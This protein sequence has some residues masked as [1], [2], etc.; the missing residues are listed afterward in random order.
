[1][2]DTSFIPAYND[3]LLISDSFW[4]IAICLVIRHPN[5]FSKKS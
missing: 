4:S 2:E 3:L 5:M 1:M